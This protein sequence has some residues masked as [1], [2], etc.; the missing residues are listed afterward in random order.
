[1]IHRLVALTLVVAVITM[2]VPLPGYAAVEQEQQSGHLVSVQD[3]HAALAARAAERVRNV[4]DVRKLLRQDLVQK[5]VGSVLAFQEGDTVATLA[6]NLLAEF[7]GMP[8]RGTDSIC[9]VP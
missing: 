8:I 4:E 9:I 1:M 7:G 5:Q 3:L 6:G 2:G